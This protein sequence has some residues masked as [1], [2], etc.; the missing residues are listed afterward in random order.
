MTRQVYPTDLSDFECDL[1]QN[2]VPEQKPDGRPEEIPKREIMNAILYVTRSGVPWR[3]LPHNLPHF[4]TVYHYFRISIVM[5]ELS[6][7]C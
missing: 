1:I 5:T 2:L 4:K 6:A 7:E 3:L